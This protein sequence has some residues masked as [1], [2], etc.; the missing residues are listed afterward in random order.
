MAHTGLL[1]P[2]PGL[3]MAGQ[4]LTKKSFFTAL[5]HL[6][7]SDDTD[8]EDDLSRQ[9]LIT[10][11]RDS[12]KSITPTLPDLVASKPQPVLLARA[13]SDP[14][15]SACNQRAPSLEPLKE[16]SKGN[17]KHS[18]D[19]PVSLKLNSAHRSYSTSSMPGTKASPASKKRKVSNAKVVPEGK[20]IFKNLVFFFFPNNDVSSLRRLRIQ[21]AQEYGARWAREWSSTITHVIVDK[22]LSYQDLVV[23]LKLESV[24]EN[25]A[26]VN[27]TY[28]PECLKYS[29]VINPSQARFRV[30]GTLLPT[31]QP[32]LTKSVVTEPKPAA[33]PPL[34]K[35]RREQNMETSQQSIES[36]VDAAYAIRAVPAGETVQK[37][38]GSKDID[39]AAGES[40]ALDDIINETKATSHLPIDANDSADE[41]KTDESGNE[42]EVSD[43]EQEDVPGAQRGK[44]LAGSWAQSFACMEEYNPA[45]RRDNPNS[46]TIDVL[47]QMLDY[48]TRNADHWHILGYRKAI[49]AL[50][51]QTQKITT[52]TQAQMI[53]GIGPRIADKIEEIVLTDHL[54]QIDNTSNTEEDRIIQ[55]FLG[56]YG[57]GLRQASDWVAQGY[58]SLSDLRDRAPL[59]KNQQI[60]VDRYHDFALRI[61]R[62]EAVQTADKDMQVIV[63]GSYRRGALD[64]GDIDCLIT[65]P[66]ATLEQIRSLMVDVVIPQL[67]RD[68]F[69]QVGLAT[70]RRLGHD[71]SKW[72]GASSLPGSKVWRRI[73]LLFV[74]GEEIGAALLYFTGTTSSIGACD[75]LLGKKG[76]RGLF[77]NVLRDSRQMKTNPGRL[78]EGRDEKRIFAL[79]G[80][81]G[82]H[83][84][85]VSVREHHVHSRSDRR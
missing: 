74:P 79:L 77:A 43:I 41:T 39:A 25:I 80:V 15:P 14:Q 63:A 64:S 33:S 85:T 13:H 84:S 66:D 18:T 28:P 76:S 48:Y 26:I 22:D 9:L 40:N 37:E 19:Q 6:D 62:K 3:A 21:R 56:I 32:P 1:S 5:E 12:K 23:H 51:R 59:T 83:R 10:S 45:A 67:F 44:K 81:P 34:K 71:G 54:R 49:A 2:D 78:L 20:Q 53:P 50:R 17:R 8:D 61:P 31:E 73:D 55:E 69:L 7:H 57:V 11:S 72:H 60:G 58:R 42:S 82:G 52:R 47:Q 30:T 68:G 35:S 4:S 36:S 70:P 27:D 29:T 24:P 65:K 16:H 46:R 38:G 75:C